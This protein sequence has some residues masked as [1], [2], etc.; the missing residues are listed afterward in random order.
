LRSRK[1]FGVRV[2]GWFGC[3]AT[4]NSDV[5]LKD[6]SAQTVDRV[7]GRWN[8]GVAPSFYMLMGGL[9]VSAT[10]QVSRAEQN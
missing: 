7:N 9:V 8:A 4:G 10:A 1:W 5:N 6:R 3:A 2:L